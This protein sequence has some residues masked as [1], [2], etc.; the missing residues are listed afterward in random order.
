MLIRYLISPFAESVCKGDFVDKKYSVES[1]IN[2]EFLFFAGFSHVNFCKIITFACC[3][4]A[5]LNDDKYPI[6]DLVCAMKTTSNLIDEINHTLIQEARISL[7]TIII[8][9]C[10]QYFKDKGFDRVLLECNYKLFDYYKNLFFN[11]GTGEDNKYPFKRNDIISA[12]LAALSNTGR[13]RDK[14][15]FSHLIITDNYIDNLVI[16]K[17][18]KA[19]KNTLFKMYFNIDR[20]FKMLKR[21]AE[22]KIW[23]IKE[24]KFIKTLFDS[25]RDSEVVKVNNYYNQLMRNYESDFK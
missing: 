23:N 7:G 4:Y 22:D 13:F 3:N 8:F 14:T 18:E 11:I 17:P 21:K 6:I 15:N 5:Y 25:I 20:Y 12:K 1:I 16:T 9:K 24:K 2:S 19:F 10:I